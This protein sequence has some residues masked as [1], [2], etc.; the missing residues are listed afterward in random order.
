VGR[1]LVYLGALGVVLYALLPFAWV[2]I[3]SISPQV[4]LTSIPP[5]V[6]PEHP[7]LDNYAR[8]LGGAERSDVAAYEFRRALLNTLVVGLVVTGAGLV[9]G[10]AAAY[11]FARMRFRGR[12]GLFLLVVFTQLLPSLALAIPLYVLLS[13]FALVNT[14][15]GLV[16]VYSSFTLPFVVWVMRGYFLS[17]PRELEEAAMI[18]GCS[19]LAALVRVVL[20]LS[21]PG[22]TATAIFSLLAVWSEFFLAVIFTSTDASKTISVVAAE[23][24]GRYSLDYGGLT[25]SAVLASLPPVVLALLTQRFIVGGLTAGGVRG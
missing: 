20:P 17:I 1:A 19:R 13:R 10:S 22:L 8:L 2:A 3:S 23:F 14:L 12:T 11:A 21:A 5:H 9:A 6:I 7:T 18:D 24:S 4:E 25:A 15:G 16:L